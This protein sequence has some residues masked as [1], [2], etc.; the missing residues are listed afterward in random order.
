RLGVI[1]PFDCAS[2]E[3]LRQ[4]LVTT[5]DDHLARITVVPRVIHGEPFHFMRSRLIEV[6]TGLEARTLAE[7]AECLKRVD[8]SSIYWHTVEARMR[9]QKKHGEFAHWIADQCKRDELA[10][11]IGRLS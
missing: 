9:R 6:P 11:E 1:D 7:F 4:E 2:L 5:L 8:A 10:E 3:G